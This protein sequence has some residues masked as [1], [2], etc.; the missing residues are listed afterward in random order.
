MALARVDTRRDYCREDICNLIGNDGVA[1]CAY[2]NPPLTT[3][4]VEPLALGN[5]RRSRVW[6]IAQPGRTA[7]AII[8]RPTLQ[9]R[10]TGKRG[11]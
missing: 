4:A 5:R 10:A 1:A 7:P 11:R 3:I 8:Y 6:R 2:G 9:I